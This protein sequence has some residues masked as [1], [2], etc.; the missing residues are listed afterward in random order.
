MFERFTQQA[1]KAMTLAQEEASRFNH[2][3]VGTGHLL[4]GLLRQEDGVAAQALSASGMK[5]EAAQDR[6]VAILGYGEEDAPAKPFTPPSKEVL[7]M[8]SKAARRLG[9]NHIGTEHLLLALASEPEGVATRILADLEIDEQALRAEVL[10]LMGEEDGDG[11]M[12][13]G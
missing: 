7:A 4:L 3:Y 12:P 6:L 13:G 2:D 5:T 10:S 9:H 11:H 1:R 8:A